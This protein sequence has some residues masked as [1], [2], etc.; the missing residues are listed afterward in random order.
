MEKK[1]CLL[2]KQ[3]QLLLA[4]ILVFGSFFGSLVF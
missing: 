2:K 4:L 1:K 3:E